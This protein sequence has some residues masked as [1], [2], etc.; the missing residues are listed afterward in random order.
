LIVILVDELRKA[1]W[2]WSVHTSAIHSQ[3]Q[4]V[5]GLFFFFFF[6]DGDH[7]VNIAKVAFHSF[8]IR[9][10]F[11]SS[12]SIFDPL[13]L[14]LDTR[15]PTSANE[16]NPTLPLHESA[17]HRWLIFEDLNS[18]PSGRKKADATLND[19]SSS[20]SGDSARFFGCFPGTFRVGSFAFDLFL[21]YFLWRFLWHFLWQ[22]F[23]R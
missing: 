10:R 3:F 2:L 23:S 16:A 18:D 15:D 4:S 21:W 11:E 9:T 6:F 20:T 13:Y 22:V 1:I 19:G 12:R 5:S 14:P 7:D 17:T 8:A